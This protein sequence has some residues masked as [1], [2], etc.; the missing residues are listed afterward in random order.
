[1]HVQ[2]RVNA[3][4]GR[5][6]MCCCT[7]LQKWKKVCE[8]MEALRRELVAEQQ[9]T[10]QSDQVSPTVSTHRSDECFCWE[11]RALAV[12]LCIFSHNWGCSM[13]CVLHVLILVRWFLEH[14]G[15]AMTPGLAVRPRSCETA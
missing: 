7:L 9:A 8:Q 10:A 1:M 2:L 14:Q 15:T 5:C 12:V 4:T 3:A 11:P 6:E 13:C